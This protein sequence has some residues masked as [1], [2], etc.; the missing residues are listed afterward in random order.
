MAGVR[1]ARIDL[2]DVWH[3]YAGSRGWALRGVS[4]SLEPGRFTVLAGP[5]G[6][7]KTTLLK[8]ASAIFKPSRGLVSVDGRDVWG[9]SGEERL[10]VRRRIVYVHDKPVMLRGSVAHN[11]AYG[12]MLRGLGRDQALGRAADFLE[13][14]GMGGLAGLDA[15]RLSAG[16]AQMVAIARALVVEPEALL[17]DEPFS[18]IDRSRRASL[19]SIF[20]DYIS[21]GGT[22]AIA[23][24]HDDALKMLPGCVAVLREGL[25]EGLEC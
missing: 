11:V 9:L 22:L 24:H 10:R 8:I 14:L 1:G 13:S 12:L 18:N 16:Q 17:L 5:N 15:K 23:S 19:I 7:G 3:R 4:L 2:E 21:S 6:A 25:L 20:E